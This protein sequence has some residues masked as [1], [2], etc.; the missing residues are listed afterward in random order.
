MEFRLIFP[1]S[2][3]QRTHLYLL[4]VS[5]DWNK[6]VTLNRGW[7]NRDKPSSSSFFLYT[8][9]PPLPASGRKWKVGSGILENKSNQVSKKPWAE[10]NF[11]AWSHL[12]AR[13]DC[14]FWFWSEMEMGWFVHGGQEDGGCCR[15]PRVISSPSSRV[16]TTH[17]NTLLH[18]KQIMQLQPVGQ[19]NILRQRRLVAALQLKQFEWL[20]F[21]GKTFNFLCHLFYFFFMTQKPSFCWTTHTGA[22]KEAKGSSKEICLIFCVFL[23]SCISANGRDAGLKH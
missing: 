4:V 12:S 19:P 22:K 23:V 7:R 15:L 3:I 20:W 18:P 8:P 6:T 2:F 5:F 14:A 11:R 13:C 10:N 16:F 21:G 9:P 17:L 1:P